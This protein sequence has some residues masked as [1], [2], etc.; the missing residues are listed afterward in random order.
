MV[1][2]SK[3]NKTIVI[4]SKQQINSNYKTKFFFIDNFKKKLISS[5]QN[6][7]SKQNSG[8]IR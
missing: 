8:S 1:T 5:K 3:Q 7:G 2:L 6:N 4:L